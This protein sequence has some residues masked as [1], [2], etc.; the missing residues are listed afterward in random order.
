M[1]DILAP[2]F[3][4]FARNFSHENNYLTDHKRQQLLSPLVHFLPRC[5][6]CGRPFM[7]TVVSAL[8]RARTRT[9]G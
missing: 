4:F 8:A 1:G 2:I 6:Y 7:G 9:D 5:H 3:F